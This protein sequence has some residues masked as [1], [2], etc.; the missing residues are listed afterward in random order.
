MEKALRYVGTEGPFPCESCR[1]PSIG[2]NILLSKV[3]CFECNHNEGRT[4][5]LA[6][7]RPLV[8]WS[9]NS[10]VD[11]YDRLLVHPIENYGDPTLPAPE[12]LLLLSDVLGLL[13]ARF[14]TEATGFTVRTSA[15]DDNPTGV[16]SPAIC[17]LGLRSSFEV[18]FRSLLALGDVFAEQE[19]GPR[20][21]M[22]AGALGTWEETHVLL[23]GTPNQRRDHFRKLK[24]GMLSPSGV[25]QKGLHAEVTS[26]TRVCSRVSTGT[27]ASGEGDT[28]FSPSHLKNKTS[29]VLLC[30]ACI[31][32]DK[33]GPRVVE[34]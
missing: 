18:E 34:N 27:C 8:G 20:R 23:G 25:A 2:F 28:L 21:R 22:I 4:I 26:S 16:E 30:R 33:H 1:E 14:N 13:T 11:A 15:Q 10:R 3:L 6:A 7:L 19:M 29:E 31:F 12:V 32:Q 5:L 24:L 17:L 9:S